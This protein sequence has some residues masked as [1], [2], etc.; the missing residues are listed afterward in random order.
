MKKQV[1]FLLMSTLIVCGLST[2]CSDDLGTGME[3]IDST[4]GFL[5]LNLSLSEATR[6]GTT[7]NGANFENIIKQ[8]DVFFFTS[9]AGEDTPATYAI[10]DE[11][12]SGIKSVSV[13]INT[14]KERFGETATSCKVIAVANCTKTKT[15]TDPTLNA[16]KTTIT[17]TDKEEGYAF[18][19]TEAPKD[20]VMTNFAQVNNTVTPNTVTWTEDGGEGTI[21]L[22]RVAAKIRV[23]LNV[24]ETIT[25]ENG[26]KWTSDRDDMRLFISNGVTKAR[27]DGSHDVELGSADYYNIVTSGSKGNTTNGGVE[28]TSD[29]ALARVLE[30]HDNQREEA[31]KDEEKYLYYNAVPYYT[32]PNSWDNAVLE[33]TQTTLTIVVPW[34]R[35]EGGKTIYKPSY[36]TIPVN[37]GTTIESNKYYYIR[38]HIGM[39]GSVT[40]EKPMEVDMQCE[41]ADWGQAEDTNVNIRPVR[42]LIFNQTEFVMNNTT[43]IEIPFMSTHDCKVVSFSG[44]FYNFYAN[45]DG[46]TIERTFNDTATRGKGTL[47]DYSIDQTNHVLKFKHDFFTYWSYNNMTSSSSSAS[48]STFT[49]G[50]S[51]SSTY[52]RFFSP[53]EI[54]I[55]VQHDT[56]DATTDAAYNEI[57]N[58]TVYPAIYY[59][60]EK[61]ET[62]VNNND[63]DWESNGWIYVNGYGT[64]DAN[65]GNLGMAGHGAGTRQMNCLTTLTVNKLN[66]EE[67]SK[68]TIDD[69]RTYY[70]NNLLSGTAHLTDNNDEMTNWPKTYNGANLTSSRTSGNGQNRIS[71]SGAKTI[72]EY[73]PNVELIGDWNASSD[74]WTSDNKRTLTYYYPCSEDVIKERVLAPKIIIASY[75]AYTNVLTREEARRRCALYQQYGYP[76][77][78]WRIPTFGEYEF[79]KTAQI[80]EV[81]RDIFNNTKTSSANGA[82]TQWTNRG[83]AH[84]TSRDVTE[85][86]GTTTGSSYVRCVYDLWYWEKVDKNGVSTG[87]IPE[88]INKINWRYFTWG[89]RPKENPLTRSGG[90]SYTVQDYL[91]ENAQGNYAITRDGNKVK[92]IKMK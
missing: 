21:Q 64:N 66:E 30:H 15:L 23:A 49:K 80:K 67:S 12:S 73:F 90:D 45:S 5:T 29:Y 84:T 26:T 83:T 3:T 76:A 7:V 54:T 47:Y 48:V 38:M 40:P 14:L 43:E 27:L 82:G 11:S 16:L 56:D 78:R 92:R 8:L 24:E 33:T 39:M 35:E 25:D 77:G 88:G 71:V 9:D 60:T 6:G 62:N 13:S 59:N 61:I 2:S 22:K 51:E 44:K 63:R 81:I 72:W 55:R 89:D 10:H 53:F 20:F 74:V 87:R 34:K 75:H 28:N 17:V 42:Y 79:I 65:T 46:E 91:E 18:R 31:P 68:W 41:I 57:I 52:H 58:L 19:S 4:K 70:I 86:T 36:Y 85:L 50:A 1:F 69:P 37:N 32:Y